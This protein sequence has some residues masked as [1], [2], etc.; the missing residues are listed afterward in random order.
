M[1]GGKLYRPELDVI[2]FL[3]FLSVFT[4]HVF[5]PLPIHPP[6]NRVLNALFNQG[7]F[8]LCLF[9][10]LSAFLIS[11]LL[12]R[13]REKNGR[14]DVG[15]FYKRRILRIWPLYILGL[16]MGII[17]ALAKH[18]Q[19]W[20]RFA[21]FF[22]LIGNWYC[23][24]FGWLTN[25]ASPLWSISVEEQF[26]L[27]WPAIARWFSRRMMSGLC[28]VLIVIANVL[29]YFYG[30]NQASTLFTVWFNSFV[31]FEMFA[32]GVLLAIVLKQRV[33]RIN[34]WLRGALL[35]SAPVLWFSAV[36][37]FNTRGD[38]PETSGAGL[39]AGFAM[40]AAGCLAIMIGMLGMPAKYIPRSLAYLGRISYGLY[41]FH[42]FGL[43]IV[44]LMLHQTFWSPTPNL[45][46]LGY[47]LMALALTIVMASISYRYFETPFLKMKPVRI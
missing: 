39:M 31:Q 16:S 17:F 3:A 34:L 13:E 15:A 27:F 38:I 7:A 8:G 18:Q 30:E 21:S 33:P 19:V 14:I 20:G 40:V 24:R 45:L 35:L 12:M 36:Y 22:L 44:K 23:M 25:P 4:R 47:A 11:D 29:L 9:F 32:C 46:L 1:V 37:F 42:E 41:V 5:S 43:A 28:I 2:R 10:V 6:I 26:Y